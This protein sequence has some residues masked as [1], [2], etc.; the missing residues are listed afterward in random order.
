MDNYWITLRSHAKALCYDKDELFGH[1]LTEYYPFFSPVHSITSAFEYYTPVCYSKEKNIPD[2]YI[3]VTTDLFMPSSIHEEART[4]WI[5]K[6]QV[7]IPIKWFFR[8]KKMNFYD[9]WDMIKISKLDLPEGITANDSLYSAMRKAYNQG[10][11]DSFMQLFYDMREENPNDFYKQIC[12]YSNSINY[13]T[14]KI[15]EFKQEIN[16]LR[17]QMD[18]TFIVLYDEFEKSSYYEKISF[19]DFCAYNLQIEREIFLDYLD[20]DSAVIKI[21]KVTNSFLKFKKENYL[22]KKDLE[23][24]ESSHSFL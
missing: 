19:L 18:E 7:A 15:D 8:I 13:L 17:Q 11:E 23:N 22:M 6:N 5:N 24:F 20:I 2:G 9:Q 4:V 16:D 21:S 1:P 12:Q 14:L 10:M 3:I